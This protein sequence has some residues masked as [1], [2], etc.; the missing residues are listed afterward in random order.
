MENFKEKVEELLDL[1]LDDLNINE[2]GEFIA[3]RNNINYKI[4]INT[5]EIIPSEDTVFKELSG[6][7]KETFKERV[8]RVLGIDLDVASLDENGVFIAM[9]ED[10]KYRVNTKTEVIEIIPDLTFGQKAVGLTFNPSG[11]EVVTRAKQLSAELIDIVE[12]KMEFNESTKA[13]GSRLS[14]T[15]N[16]FRTA[17]F[18][19]IIAA[20][21]AVVKFLT[22]RD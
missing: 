17:A 19:A 22:Y 5:E 7:N 15:T 10:I 14:W 8:Q 11:D 16:V 6:K 2:T 4:N 3:V 18:N 12:Q 9:F 1:N 21:M 13:E 20:Q